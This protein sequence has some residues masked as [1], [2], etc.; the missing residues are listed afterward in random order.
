MADKQRQRL[1]QLRMHWDSA[2]T[3]RELQW[4]IERELNC[5]IRQMNLWV[6][7]NASNYCVH[8]SNRNWSTHYG[9]G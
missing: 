8:L 1:Q 6:P 9:R 4:D 5:L 2:I 3:M 7:N